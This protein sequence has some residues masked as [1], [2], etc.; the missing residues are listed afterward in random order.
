ME[1]KPNIISLIADCIAKTSVSTSGKNT[2]FDFAIEGAIAIGYGEPFD[3]EQRE[4]N[5]MLN[6]ANSDLQTCTQIWGYYYGY[7]IAQAK[8]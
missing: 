8:S 6:K 1:Q 5:Q 7:Q 4:I 2:N 3:R